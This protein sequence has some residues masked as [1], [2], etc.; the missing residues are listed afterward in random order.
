MAATAECRVMGPTDGIALG[1]GGQP[2]HLSGLF[3]TNYHPAEGTADAAIRDVCIAELHYTPGQ[4]QRFMKTI[5]DHADSKVKLPRAVTA[6]LTYDEV[7]V[8]AWYT[9]DVRGSLEL[10]VEANGWW[11]MNDCLRRRD[12]KCLRRFL[13]L[14]FFLHRAGTAANHRRRKWAG[15]DPVARNFR[16]PQ[17]A[18]QA[19]RRASARVLAGIHVGDQR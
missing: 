4:L 7:L 15:T 16:T 6:A 19:L 13:P 14:I 5:V 11:C 3:D 18:V 1:D 8:I 12:V 9:S 10:P 17:H 2:V